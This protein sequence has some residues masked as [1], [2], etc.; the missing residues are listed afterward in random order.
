M[1]LIVFSCRVKMDLLDLPGLQ[2]T[3]ERR[4]A[5]CFNYN[6]NW[7]LNIFFLVVALYKMCSLLLHW[8]KGL[9]GNVGPKGVAG[10]DGEEVYCI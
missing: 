2:E 10:V 4:W 5:N 9:G 7:H 3:K 8:L 6:I 1:N